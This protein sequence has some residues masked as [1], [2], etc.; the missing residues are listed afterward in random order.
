VIVAAATFE[1]YN[2]Q[3]W[4][5]NG[6]IFK[7][8]NFESDNF[9]KSVLR[10]T[11]F[12]NTTFL[13]CN[14]RDID[15]ANASFKDCKFEKCIFSETNFSNVE[16]SLIRFIDCGFYATNFTKTSLSD[17]DLRE[18]D[19][20]EIDFSSCFF[21]NVQAQ[22]VKTS[23][24]SAFPHDWPL[25]GDL[26]IGEDQRTFEIEL[27]Q[28]CDLTRLDLKRAKGIY[29]YSGLPV[30][31]CPKSVPDDVLLDDNR[32]FS[33]FTLSEEDISGA[34][35]EGKN[36]RAWKLYR[37]KSGKVTGAVSLPSGWRLVSGYLVGPTANL[38]FAKLSGADLSGLDLSEVTFR[39]ADLFGANFTNCSLDKVD[40]S[41]ANVKNAIFPTG[42]VP[43]T[44]F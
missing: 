3:D 33:N 35:L 6:A 28:N 38:N 15:F 13:N 5:V 36:L 19:L 32:L 9:E 24:S 29:G 23:L 4:N 25:P 40:F 44:G 42:F 39:S 27:L 11:Y 2:I 26:D 18:S 16:F 1:G 12:E 37:V 21:E 30:I 14:F 17:V 34:H 31:G 41:N 10:G 8:L 7:S 43:N 22:N 20:G